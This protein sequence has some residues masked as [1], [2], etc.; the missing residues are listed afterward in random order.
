M[1]GRLPRRRCA[2]PLDDFSL[3]GLRPS[4]HT[5]LLCLQLPAAV[6]ATGPNPDTE[7]LLS[8]AQGLAASSTEEEP[9][10]VS[11]DDVVAKRTEALVEAAAA[12]LAKTLADAPPEVAARAVGA[13]LESAEA[14]HRGYVLG[15]LAAVKHAA[16][17][18]KLQAAGRLP[19]SFLAGSL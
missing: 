19:T 18:G 3:A 1:T 10:S 2:Q 7:W 5:L 4:S 15:D 13:L 17:T 12:A 6:E 9:L 8:L 16:G 11:L 14:T